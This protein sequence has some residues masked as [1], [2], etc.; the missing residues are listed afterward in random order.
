METKKTDRFSNYHARKNL[1]QVRATRRD[2]DLLPLIECQNS[3]VVDFRWR[4]REDYTFLSSLNITNELNHIK[5]EFNSGR[6]SFGNTATQYEP[7]FCMRIFM[8]TPEY[9]FQR[10]TDGS[11]R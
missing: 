10:N 2:G 5:S 11:V 1:R 9:C 8:L 7:D 6:L 4:L 3:A